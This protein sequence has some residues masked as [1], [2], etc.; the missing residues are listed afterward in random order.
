[1]QMLLLAWGSPGAKPVP[2]RL[3][4]LREVLVVLRVT[5]Q[6]VEGHGPNSHVVRKQRN[7]RLQFVRCKGYDV[8]GHEKYSQ[9]KAVVTAFH[10]KLLLVH[11]SAM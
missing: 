8:V 1:M 11:A 7:G 9:I 3:G 10:A 2:R 6:G 4:Q 5:R